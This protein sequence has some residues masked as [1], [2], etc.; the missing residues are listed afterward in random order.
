MN[1][2]IVKFNEETLNS[3]INGV[4]TAVLMR[5]CKLSDWL[6]IPELSDRLSGTV[7]KNAKLGMKVTDQL[8]HEALCQT[9][10]W[11]WES[12]QSSYLNYNDAISEG[13][14]H[15]ITEAGWFA[16]RWL[17]TQMFEEE[18]YECKYIIVDDHSGNRREGIGLI[19]RNTLI[20]WIQ[21]GSMVFCI[22][23]E[24]DS[25]NKQWLDAQNPF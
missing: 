3:K 8:R 5:N 25:K 4:K 11:T 13:D 17:N 9:L 24:W 15:S 21:P 16:D 22:L 23:A 12:V 14:C 19:C 20:Q 18:Y 10:G 7:K 2:E 6:K 1:T